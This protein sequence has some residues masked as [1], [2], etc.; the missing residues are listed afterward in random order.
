[1]ADYFGQWT[2]GKEW[3]LD[4]GQE[5]GRVTGSVSQRWPDGSMHPTSIEKIITF[6]DGSFE[7]S[8]PNRRP[9]RSGI[10]AYHVVPVDDTTLQVRQ[11]FK[12][13]NPP[14]GEMGGEMT[15]TLKRVR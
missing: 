3:S 10:I 2:D 13:H 4:L 1:M 15:F 12:I 5:D 8:Y 7:V 11:H 14:S 9:P 6:E